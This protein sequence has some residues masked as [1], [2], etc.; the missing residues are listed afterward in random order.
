MSDNKKHPWQLSEPGAVNIVLL[1]QARQRLAEKQRRMVVLTTFS[2][3]DCEDRVARIMKTCIVV[4]GL[5]SNMKFW[6][7]ELSA[8]G[9][10]H[11]R[12]LLRTAS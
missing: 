5:L 9:A 4:A 12:E 3:A 11:M 6:V 1:S 10:T 7:L 2:T 8:N